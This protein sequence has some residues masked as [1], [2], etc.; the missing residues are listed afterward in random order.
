MKKKLKYEPPVI[1]NIRQDMPQ[2]TCTADC[3]QGNNAMDCS[4]GSCVNSAWCWDGSQAAYCYNGSS[5]CSR[6]A[7][8]CQNGN[9]V[10]GI[11]TDKCYCIATGT[12]AAYY[13]SGGQNA[14]A[15]LCNRGQYVGKCPY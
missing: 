14:Y 15:S 11:T 4:N 8:C 9:D 5:A 12:S 13:C 3:Y 10:K 7:A 6:C 2:G 1:V